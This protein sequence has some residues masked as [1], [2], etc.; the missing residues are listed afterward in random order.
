MKSRQ[1]VA[2]VLMAMATVALVAQQPAP[3]PP[4]R[5]PIVAVPLKEK[6]PAPLKNLGALDKLFGR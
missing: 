1:H 4:A 3:T 2:V 6:K 5:K